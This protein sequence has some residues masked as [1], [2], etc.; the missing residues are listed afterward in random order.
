MSLE[1][2]EE[3]A[4]PPVPHPPKWRFQHTE[5]GAAVTGSSSSDTGFP[6]LTGLRKFSWE[7]CLCLLFASGT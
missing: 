6:V 4:S 7:K 2:R 3:G 1:V 5:L